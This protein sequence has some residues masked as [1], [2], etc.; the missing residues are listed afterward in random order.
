MGAPAVRLATG[1]GVKKQ[2]VASIGGMALAFLAGQH[3]N[4]H[5]ALLTLGLGGS[6][7]TFME[8]YPSIR[9]GMLVMS[10]VVVAVN[11]RSV[12]R[13]PATFAMRA[14]IVGSSGL[15]LGVIAWSLLRFGL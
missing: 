3:H 4:L 1:E 6:G 15:T 11:L 2:G 7:M 10:L 5:L 8:V 12:R 13:A 9:R 14:L